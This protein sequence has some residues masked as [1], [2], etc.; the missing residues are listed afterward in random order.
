MDNKCK[1]TNQKRKIPN[2]T[3]TNVKSNKKSKKIKYVFD[4][5]YERSTAV[6]CINTYDNDFI[7]IDN[8]DDDIN[9]KLKSAL[10]EIVEQQLFDN[11]NKNKDDNEKL[12]GF[13]DIGDNVK[14]SYCPCSQ[15]YIDY[16]DEQS[17]T[18][19]IIFID[20]KNDNMFFSVNDSV[21]SEKITIKS[22]EREGCHFMGMTRGYD[23]SIEH[24]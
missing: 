9:D 5:I 3:N 22:L 2:E 14:V 13:Y 24:I 20:S 1:F 4:M 12:F 18:G 7:D 21:T 10:I 6:K 19:R 23:Y 15:K 16:Y 8:T 17:F 11:K